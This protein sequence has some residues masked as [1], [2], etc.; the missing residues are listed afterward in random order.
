M[1]YKSLLIIILTENC[2]MRWQSHSNLPTM[3]AKILTICAIYQNTLAEHRG[4]DPVHSSVWDNTKG[5]LPLYKERY[6]Y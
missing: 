6:L 2:N 5:P 3:E 1:K 4:I